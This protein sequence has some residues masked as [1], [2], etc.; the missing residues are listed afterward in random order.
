MLNYLHSRD[1]YLAPGSSA[2]LISSCIFILNVLSDR[3]TAVQ[4]A[5]R[6]GTLT[7]V[8]NGTRFSPVFLNL[9][10]HSC[11]SPAVFEINMAILLTR[12]S[13]KLGYLDRQ[14]NKMETPM[15]LFI[16]WYVHSLIQIP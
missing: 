8:L 11:P 9:K 10:S 5:P 6:A 16:I 15:K 7:V 2:I 4:C 14:A 13:V 1:K 3:C 12:T